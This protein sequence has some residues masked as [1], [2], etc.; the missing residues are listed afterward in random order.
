MTS[1]LEIPALSRV[2]IP[3][4]QVRT[5]AAPNSVRRGKAA[6]LLGPAERAGGL[7][8]HQAEGLRL[9][10]EGRNLVAATATASGKSLIFQTWTLHRLTQDDEARA[11]V[12]YRCKNG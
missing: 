2:V 4:T 9:L 6:P 3:P 1:Q 5:G 11:L 7:W 8:L 12:F 10:E